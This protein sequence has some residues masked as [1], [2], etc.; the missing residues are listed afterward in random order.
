MSAPSNIMMSE[1]DTLPSLPS[2]GKILLYPKTN[3]TFYTLN[4]SG[5]ESTLG[6]G[7]SGSVT[8][9]T[10]TGVLGQLTSTGSP[11]VTSGTI[12]LGLANSGVS[13]GS[14]SSANIVVDSFGRIVSAAN[15]GGGGGG[16][17]VGI[18]D[19]APASTTALGVGSSTSITTG[20]DNTALGY[21]S[22]SQTRIGSYNVALGK[23][24]L[25]NNIA[26]SNNVS[27][28]SE[29]LYANTASYN[30]AV[31]Q[32][33]MYGNDSGLA[34]TAVG[35]QSLYTNI[36]GSD[37]TAIGYYSLNLATNATGGNTGIGSNTLLTCS[38]GALNT[39]VGQGSLSALTTE[40]NCSGLGSG[41]AIT[42]SNQVQLGNSSTTTYAYGAVQNR[43]DVRDKT[44]I[45]DTVLGLSFIDALRPVDFKWDMREDYRTGI[46]EKADLTDEEY[47]LVRD[48]WLVNSKLANIT[49]DG[50]HTRTRKH[51]GLIAQEVKTLI[52]TEGLDFGGFQNHALAGGD[53]VMSIGYE[54]LIGP[55]I[56][57]IQELK[58]E[59]ELLKAK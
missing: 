54:E 10:V 11:I 37:N 47:A 23:H 4:S 40:T 3:G 26:G 44:E 32:A 46:P 45:T 25:Y 8:S 21:N 30:V 48:E 35:T 39:A 13:A 56:K 31:G 14:Y 52:D 20:I 6:G 24:S 5:V 7:G 36:L 58:A 18:T 1:G 15:G 22:L 59:I 33:S 38:T 53:D 29:S 43:S 27:I 41:T 12:T 17:L 16:S 9:V 55:M 28:G 57:A 51:H 42:G 19:N 2:A 34:N 49:H 50:T